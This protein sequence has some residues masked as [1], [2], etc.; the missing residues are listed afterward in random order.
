MLMILASQ[1]ILPFTKPAVVQ[2][3]IAGS[4]TNASVNKQL[5][6]SQVTAKI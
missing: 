3:N 1:L 4:N 5:L 2:E 6:F